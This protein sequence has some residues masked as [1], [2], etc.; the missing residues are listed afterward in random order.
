MRS[1]VIAIG[2][3]I[4]IGQIVNSNASYIGDKLF[5]SGIP[6]EKMV[7]IG[8]EEKALMD[9]LKD[10]MQNYDVTIITGGLGPTHDDLTKP[11]LVKFFNDELIFD[12]EVFKDVKEIFISR[13]VVMPEMNK[14]QAMVPKTCTV[15]RNPNGTAPGMWFEKEGKIIVSLPGVPYEMI[16]MMEEFVLPKLGEI[17]K[18]KIDYVLKYRT[19]LTTGIGESTLFEKLGD[20]NDILNGGKLAYLPSAAGVRLRVQVKEKNSDDADRLLDEAEKF[21][22]EK[23]GDFVFGIGDERQK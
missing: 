7:T 17:F 20:L 11:V 18:D 8:D 21:I 13:G 10:S 9:E 23:A 4:L 3:E 15:I 14:E 16:A 6:V 2:D 12:D 19:I 22:R 1:K 5:Q